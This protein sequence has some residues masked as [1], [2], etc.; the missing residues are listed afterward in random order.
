MKAK[1]VYVKSRTKN[2]TPM[3]NK[4]DI[5]KW[6]LMRKNE[7]QRKSDMYKYNN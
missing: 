3:Q 6:N 7:L 1:K 2:S 4:L 5:Q